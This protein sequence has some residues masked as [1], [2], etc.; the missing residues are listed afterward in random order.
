MQVQKL[1]P[2]ATSIV[3]LRLNVGSAKRRVRT[4]LD[5]PADRIDADFPSGVLVMIWSESACPSVYC[6]LDYC[7]DICFLPK[8]YSCLS[9]A[10]IRCLDHD[11]A[12]VGVISV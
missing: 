4:S 2:I 8:H 1:D 6:R 11:A 5:I 7:C 3:H 10:D 9:M 12:G